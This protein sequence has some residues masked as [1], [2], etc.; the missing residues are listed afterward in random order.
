MVAQ[1]EIIIDEKNIKI[2]TFDKGNF[3]PFSTIN[4]ANVSEYNNAVIEVKNDLSGYPNNIWIGNIDIKGYVSDTD[5]R[6]PFTGKY[7]LSCDKDGKP[8]RFLKRIDIDILNKRWCPRSEDIQVICLETVDIYDTTKHEIYILDT[9]DGIIHGIKATDVDDM[10][11]IKDCSKCY[12]ISENVIMFKEYC[13]LSE[14]DEQ[15]DDKGEENLCY[16]YCLYNTKTHERVGFLA[17]VNAIVIR[18]EDR[19]Y[20]E[21]KPIIFDML[22]VDG[23]GTERIDNVRLRLDTLTVHSKEGEDLVDYIIEDL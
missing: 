3:V 16:H 17:D 20:E 4:A 21:D 6:N 11:I 15:Y 5:D 18:L 13:D 8:Y 7:M 1:K 9:Y 12:F 14:W 10:Y 2:V 19:K 22:H 23:Y